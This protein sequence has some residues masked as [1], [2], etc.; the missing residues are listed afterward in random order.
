M[1]IQNG[2]EEQNWENVTTPLDDVERWVLATYAMWSEY[3]S[4]G[5]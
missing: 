2:S 4:E 5:G 1:N 3:Y